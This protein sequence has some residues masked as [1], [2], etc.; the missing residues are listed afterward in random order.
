MALVLVTIMEMNGPGGVWVEELVFYTANEEQ[1]RKI[2]GTTSNKLERLSDKIDRNTR[3]W[4]NDRN[5]SG[6]R[7]KQP[8]HDKSVMISHVRTEKTSCSR[9]FKW[10]YLLLF[11]LLYHC[12]L[13][14]FVF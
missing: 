12:R 11:L 7:D 13:N 6:K 1:V 4:E 10:E 8:S 3:R 2:K 5:N 9:F 14:I